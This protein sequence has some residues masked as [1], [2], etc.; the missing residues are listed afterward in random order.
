MRPGAISGRTSL[1]D[2]GRLVLATGDQIG[3]LAHDALAD[4]RLALLAVEGDQVAA[5]ED[6]AVEM[7]LDPALISEDDPGALAEAVGLPAGAS[8]EDL[9]DRLADRAEPELLTNLGTR[10]L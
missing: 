7:G 9:R 8:W 1:G 5:Q 3:E 4:H 10:G 2:G 6:L